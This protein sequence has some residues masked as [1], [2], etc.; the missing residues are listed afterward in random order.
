MQDLLLRYRAFIR[1]EGLFRQ[2]Q[3][4]LLALSGGLDSSVLLHLTVASGYRVELAHANFQL[5]GEESDRDEAF[6]RQLASQYMLTLHVKPFNTSAYAET[7]KLSIQEAARELRYNWFSELLAERGL[8]TIVTAHHADDN[9]ETSLMNL[10]KGT[11]IAGMRGILPS[12]NH[13]ARPLLFASRAELEQYAFTH[14]I[15]HVEDSSNLSEKYTRNFFRLNI[16]PLIEQVYPG[17]M[18]NLRANMARFREVEMLYQEAVDRKRRKLLRQ[19]G[20]EWHIP[21]EAL[22][23]SR[24]L[25]TI[26]HEIF[27]KFSFTT[28]QLPEIEKLMDSQTGR[29]ISSATHRLT[30]NRNWFIIGRKDQEA[31]SV[32]SIQAGQD[33][34]YFPQGM[35]RISEPGAIAEIPKDAHIAMLDMK[36]LQ[37]PLLLRKW[38]QGDYLY[39]LG[40]EK[41]KKVARLLI[42][43]KLS[44]SDKEKV[45]VLESNKKIIWV[46]GIR[47]DH[48]FRITPS[49]STALRIS[50]V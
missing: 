31:P 5:R 42:D 29:S 44:A 18:E 24:P 39:P 28:G 32:I 27:S 3:P 50:L 26:M 48:R 9:V 7:H 15:A 23:F 6:V 14:G 10:F 25:H 36:G 8:H 37:F 30:R 41:K 19:V 4:L 2:D 43:M 12:G 11:G 49:T 13:I 46:V 1:K 22:R 20:E 47:I 38:R 16:I 45:W 34:V 40:M 21:V 33:S 17:T 35:L